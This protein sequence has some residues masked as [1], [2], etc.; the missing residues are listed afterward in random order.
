MKSIYVSDIKSIQKESGNLKIEQWK[1]T[2]LPIEKK[3]NPKKPL[4]NLKSIKKSKNIR[5]DHYKELRNKYFTKLRGN[6]NVH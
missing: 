1:F 5:K 3:E 6:S 2:I 4:K